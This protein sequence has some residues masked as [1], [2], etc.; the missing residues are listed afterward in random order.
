MTF[1]LTRRA[2]LLGLTAA[3]TSGR[4]SLALADAATDRRFAVVILRGALDGMQAVI[5]YGDRN[6]ATWRPELIPP[7]PGQPGGMLDLG[8]FFGLHPMLD[9]LHAMYTDGEL[10][11]VH[12]VAGAYRSRSHFEAQ[13]FM[14]MG[15]DHRMTSGWL[16]RAVSVLP[17]AEAGHSPGGPALA[18][19]MSVPLLLRGPATVGSWAP[20]SFGKPNPDLYLRMAALNSADPVTG[21]AIAEGLRERG[22]TAD[23]LA[24]IAEPATP[25]DKNGFPALAAAAG[26][27]LAAD[28]GPRIAALEVGGWD[29]H[30]G[31]MN[32]LGGPLRQ[33]NDGLV[34]LKTSLG[35]AWPHTAI[36]VMTEFGRTVRMNGTKGTDHGTGTVAFVL[37][38]AVAGGRVQANWP[39]LAQESLFENR[40]LRPTA[41]LRSVAKG[42]LAQHLRLSATALAAIFPASD[43][44][45]PMPNLLRI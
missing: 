27:M 40:D 44:A 41:D 20:Q 23:A 24:D 22:F 6:L 15:A 9:G 31:Q 17:A 45:P 36:L 39:G 30:S 35:R 4:S 13:D 43:S 33:L 19:G 16:N 38:G 14:E 32:R 34:A 28:D 37:G 25:R 3:W 2:A 26:K 29:T 1:H 18:V 21:P 42:L 11:P 12:A 7:A 5:P 10:L 8:G